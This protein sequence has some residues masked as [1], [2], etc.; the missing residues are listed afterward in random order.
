MCSNNEITS[1][2]QKPSNKIVN[3]T[4]GWGKTAMGALAKQTTK[5]TYTL[6][7]PSAQSSKF[8]FLHHLVT[9]NFYLKSRMVT[10]R[11]IRL[12]CVDSLHDSPHTPLVEE[13]QGKSQCSA[14]S[15]NHDNTCTRTTCLTDY[16]STSNTTKHTNFSN[17]SNF[18][19]SM[20]TSI[21]IMMLM[22][23]AETPRVTEIR[24]SNSRPPIRIENAT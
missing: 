21:P 2:L 18:Y 12:T 22:G 10:K 16:S 1:L 13:F 20:V 23:S 24:T 14:E 7:P 9:Y 19:I 11:H 4:F 5:W 15:K 3:G 17:K 8:L 6:P